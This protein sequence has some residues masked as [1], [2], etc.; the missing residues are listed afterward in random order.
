MTVISKL[1]KEYYNLH[2]TLVGWIIISRLRND[3]KREK[4]YIQVY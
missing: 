4:K 1:S 3:T 2:H